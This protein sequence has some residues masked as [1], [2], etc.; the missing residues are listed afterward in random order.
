MIE[1]QQCPESLLSIRDYIRLCYSQMMQQK[2]YLGHGHVNAIDEAKQLVLAA[3]YLPWDADDLVLDARLLAAEKQRILAFMHRRIKQREPLPYIINQAWFMQMP[4]FVDSR[5]LIPRSPIAQLIE[6]QFSPFLRTGP[7]NRI[8]DLCTGSG[9][10]GIACAYAFEEA[11]VDLADIST[12]ALAVASIN[13]EQHKMTEQ[14]SIIESDLFA[15][16]E[17][18]YDLIVSNPP[19][20]DKKDLAE[21]PEEYHHEPELALGSGDDG[22]ELCKIMLAQACNYL[23]EDGLL[24]VEVGNSEVH[25]MQQFPQVPFIWVELAEGGNGV[26]VIS[27]AELKQYAALF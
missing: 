3:V 5:V 6:T 22:L 19:Y 12:D 24:V 21:M 23:T 17:L 18:K 9:C 2:I 1:Q 13:I 27:A 10:I 7:V 25:L 16:I 15:N 20:V 4:F 8:L 14:V 11:Q 26:F